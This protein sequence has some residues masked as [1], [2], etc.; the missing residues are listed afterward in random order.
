MHFEFLQKLGVDY[1]CFHDRDIAPEGKTLTESNHL[2]DEVCSSTTFT[3][4]LFLSLTHYDSFVQVVNYIRQKQ[5]NTGIKVLWGT[6][7]LFS[8]RRYMNGA[9]TN[10]D[11]HV[12]AYAAA[13]VIKKDKI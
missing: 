5:A 10:P 7:N 3:D 11:A 8:H 9:A 4:I 12:F 13:Q 1:W 6:A 2:L